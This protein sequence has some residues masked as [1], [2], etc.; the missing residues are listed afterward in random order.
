MLKIR[1]E[2]QVGQMIEIVN[3]STGEV[4]QAT[5]TAYAFDKMRTIGTEPTGVMVRFGTAPAPA[6]EID[7]A[8]LP[9]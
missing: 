9:R 5:I 6:V 8:Y 3:P 4:E 2:F 7:G 1:E